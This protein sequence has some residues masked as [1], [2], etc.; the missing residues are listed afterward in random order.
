[1]FLPGDQIVTTVDGTLGSTGG[2][3]ASA[4]VDPPGPEFVNYVVPHTTSAHKAAKTTKCPSTTNSTTPTTN[5][6]T[7]TQ[8]TTG[9]NDTM[10]HPHCKP[11]KT[12]GVSKQEQIAALLALLKA[13]TQQ[14][15]NN[16]GSSPGGSGGG[17]AGGGSSSGS[18]GSGSGSGCGLAALGLGQRLRLRLWQRLGLGQ[19]VRL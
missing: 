18:G 9:A 16:H 8:S 5:T 13:E 7:T 6:G 12:K 10:T 17:N 19:R 1:M 2:A 15:K 4:T 11:K 3:S 14:L